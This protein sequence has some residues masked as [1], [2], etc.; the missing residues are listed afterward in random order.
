M[1]NGHPCT[2]LNSEGGWYGILK[3]P[4][5]RSDEEWALGL[6]RDCGIYVLPGYLF[7][8][9]EGA[10]SVFSLLTSER[11]LRPAMEGIIEYAGNH[12]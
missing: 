3:F 8:F 4:Q 6:L 2:L 11:L 12:C 5:T 9:D 1:V 10:F 7:D